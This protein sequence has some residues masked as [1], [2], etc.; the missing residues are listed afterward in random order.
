M[1]ATPPSITE[2]PT[3]NALLC[4]FEALLSS[5]IQGV[6]FGKDAKTLARSGTPPRIVWTPWDGMTRGTDSPGGKPR[7]VLVRAAGLRIWCWGADWKHTEQMAMEVMFCL[8][9]ATNGSIE[10]GRD[11]W[12]FE[13][14]QNADVAAK[15]AVNVLE[16][17]IDLPVFDLPDR[18]VVTNPTP[19]PSGTTFE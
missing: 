16:C 14:E 4:S 2:Q 19:V 3:L 13:T 15:G 7:T 10:W 17:M 12:P 9:N 8:Q 11:T 1:T 5:R 6:T 18:A